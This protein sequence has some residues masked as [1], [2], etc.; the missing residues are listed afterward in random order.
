MKGQIFNEWSAEGIIEMVPINEIDKWRHYL[1]HQPVVNLQGTTK[2]RPV[3]DA[4]LKEKRHPSLNQC[5]DKG[6]NLMELIRL[7]L[8]RFRERKI[9]VVSDINKTFSQVVVNKVDRDYLRFL[10]TVDG[11]TSVFDTAGSA[12]SCIQPFYIIGYHHIT[13]GRSFREGKPRYRCQL[14]ERVSGKT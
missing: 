10:W 6:T 13:S 3:F 8:N 4:S 14:V 7:S 9:G 5:L 11:G 12:W 1:P 2:I